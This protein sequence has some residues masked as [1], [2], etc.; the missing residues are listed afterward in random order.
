MRVERITAS[1]ERSPCSGPLLD[2]L[3]AFF[4]RRSFAH[5]T[6]R[7]RTVPAILYCYYITQCHCTVV[8]SIVNK[9][10]KSGHLFIY[11]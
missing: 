4:E 9:C 1:M 5:G 10:Y 2:L 11:Q 6:E 7:D 8:V 3:F